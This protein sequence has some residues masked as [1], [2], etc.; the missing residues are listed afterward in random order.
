MH[1]YARR[2]DNGSGSPPTP[3][4]FGPASKVHSAKAPIPHS[5]HP[6][7][8]V[9]FAKAYYSFSQVYCFL[10]LTR[11]SINPFL[12][13]GNLKAFS[14]FALQAVIPERFPHPHNRLLPGAV[15]RYEPGK[16]GSLQP[17]YRILNALRIASAPSSVVVLGKFRRFHLPIFSLFLPN[18]VFSYIYGIF[19]MPF[20]GFFY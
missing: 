19:S 5:H 4:V 6:R 8:S 17:C 10:L 1:H 16:P 18:L 15:N 20:G 7:L 11:Y 14:R 12:S 9:I 3:T 13:I 2:S